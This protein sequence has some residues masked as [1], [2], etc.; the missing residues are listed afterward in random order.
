[1]TDVI[2]TYRAAVKFLR[3]SDVAWRLMLSYFITANVSDSAGKRHVILRGFPSIVCVRFLVSSTVTSVTVCGLLTHVMRCRLPM[4]N[5]T[6][7]RRQ[8]PRSSFIVSG[9]ARILLQGGTGAW[10]TGSEVRGDK[11]IQKWNPSVPT[12]SIAGWKARSRLLIRDNWTF[13]ASSYGWDVISR[14]WSKVMNFHF[15]R[16]HVAFWPIIGYPMV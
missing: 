7:C 1:M 14:Y 6:C 12:S 9:V 4:I 11:V 13:F 5:A 15:V 10:R 3:E 16:V 2:P 8:M